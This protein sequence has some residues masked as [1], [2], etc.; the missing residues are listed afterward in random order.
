MKTF[1]ELS[2]SALTARAYDICKN[3]RGLVVDFLWVLVQMKKRQTALA[4]GF[5]SLFAF[6]VEHCGLSKGE[7]WRR[8]E[9]AKLLARF[10]IVG[11]YLADRRLT[12]ESLVTL[13]EVLEEARLQEILD[14]A[15]GRTLEEV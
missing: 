11:E 13:R 2:D 6:C 4:L 5:S 1:E 3:E 9:A 10:P 15:A 7:T 8:T 12:L 14:R